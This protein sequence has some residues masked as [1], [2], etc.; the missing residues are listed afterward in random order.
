VVTWIE[1]PHIE[2]LQSLSAALEGANGA[3]LAVPHD[4]YG[5]GA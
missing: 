1:R 3:V 4:A 5:C 2:V